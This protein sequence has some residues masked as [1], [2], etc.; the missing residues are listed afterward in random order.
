MSTLKHKSRTM[1]VERCKT[2]GVMEQSK[3]TMAR[4][5]IKSYDIRGQIEA[6]HKF[7]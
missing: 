1:K 5:D 2:S 7:I 4:A 6:D 3:F